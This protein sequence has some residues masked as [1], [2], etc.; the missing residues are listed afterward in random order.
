MAHW[1]LKTEPSTYSFDRLVR[2]RNT[3]WDGVTNPV[4]LKHIRALQLFVFVLFLESV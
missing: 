2:E 4:A 1:I 3:R